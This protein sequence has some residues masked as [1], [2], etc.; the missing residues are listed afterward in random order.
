MLAGWYIVLFLLLIMIHN[1]SLKSLVGIYNVIDM[2]TALYQHVLQD[3]THIYTCI[4]QFSVVLLPAILYLFNGQL[5]HSTVDNLS[6]GVLVS[7]QFHGK[8]VLQGE[9]LRVHLKL[10]TRLVHQ[11][12]PM[13]ETITISIDDN[14]Y[15]SINARSTEKTNLYKQIYHT[16]TGIFTRMLH[17]YRVYS[18]G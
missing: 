15:G 5:F 1:L 10:L 6:N 3:S 18:Y 14:S 11:V 2:S 13:P 7:V 17:L 4:H 12:L 16:Y 9:G 8:H